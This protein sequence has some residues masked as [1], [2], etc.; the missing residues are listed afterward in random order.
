M[1][2]GND[3]LQSWQEILLDT[4]LLCSS[5]IQDDHASQDKLTDFK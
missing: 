3:C 2:Y 4:R 1:Q 5:D